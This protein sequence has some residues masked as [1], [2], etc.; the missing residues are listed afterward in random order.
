[1]RLL[2][3]LPCEWAL[4]RPLSDEREVWRELDERVG[5]MLTNV[6]DAGVG[7]GRPSSEE[8]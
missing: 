7:V 5:G 1:M 4:S 8:W 3:E 6:V 2:E